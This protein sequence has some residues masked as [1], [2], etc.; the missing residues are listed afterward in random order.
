M[1]VGLPLAD[2][3]GHVT[4]AVNRQKATNAL[5]MEAWRKVRRKKKWKVARPN[6]KLVVGARMI[7]KKK[8]N[9]CEV[10]KCRRC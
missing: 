8:R 9:D 2:S 7:Y 10:E 6:D 4:G 1:K 5:E 3:E